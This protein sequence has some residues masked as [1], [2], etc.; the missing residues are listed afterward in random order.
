MFRLIRRLICLL[1]AG[2]A[3]FLVISVLKGG[4]PFRWFGKKTEEAGRVIHE[5]SEELAE[6]ADRVHK[7]KE[8]LKKGVEEID[9]I[10]RGITEK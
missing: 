8:E 9:R 2:V 7:T 5:K 4:E 10:K 1:V 6:K 3:A